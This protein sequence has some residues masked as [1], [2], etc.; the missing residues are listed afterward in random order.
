MRTSDEE[1]IIALSPQ[2]C[3]PKKSPS[4]SKST[5]RLLSKQSKPMEKVSS[6][7]DL[8]PL[9]PDLAVCRNMDVIFTLDNFVH[10]LSGFQQVRVVHLVKNKIQIQIPHRSTPYSG[11]TGTTARSHW[12]PSTPSWALTSWK[13]GAPRLW[14]LS[15]LKIYFFR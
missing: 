6:L 5:P 7:G 8:G 4:T 14:M 11:P 2:F 15:R 12:T 1:N 10:R 9:L 3:A 13:R